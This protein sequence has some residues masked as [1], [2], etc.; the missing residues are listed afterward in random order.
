M[1]REKFGIVPYV[2]TFASVIFFVFIIIL[3]W[4]HLDYEQEEKLQKIALLFF[5]IS[6]G[7]FFLLPN[8]SLQSYTPGDH[9]DSGRDND[10]PPYYVLRALLL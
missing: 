2:A 5:M 7:P 3:M 6:F 9:H 8:S 1:D 4:K 10:C